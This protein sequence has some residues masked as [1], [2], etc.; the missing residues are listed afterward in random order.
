M[1]RMTAAVTMLLVGCGIL[2]GKG[3]AQER[4]LE[5]Q[6]TPED[7]LVEIVLTDGS[8]LVGR[9]VEAGDPFRFTLVSGVEMNIPV[10]NVRSIARAEGMVE[11]GEYYRTDPNRTRLFFGPTAR[12]LPSGQGYLAVYEIFM[13]FVGVAITDRFIM[14]AGTP[15]IFDDDWDRPFWVAPKLKVFDSGK[16]QG[17][18]GVLAVGVEEDTFGLLYGV[19]T[20][21][22]EKGS[23][24]LGMGYGF[25]NS[26]LSDKP[27]LMIGGEA[28]GSQRVKFVTE[29]YIIPGEGGLLS[30]GPRFF[31]EKL[32][33]DL[34]L[35]L[36]IGADD[37]V[38][39]PLVNFVYNF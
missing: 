22:D 38:V 20:R 18:V 37:F 21:G 12:T 36:P 1:G 17:A 23:F 28:R 39:F 5:I 8:T 24:T 14:A 10:A 3:A 27:F 9:V 13:P 33:A 2:V 25:E 6:V 16:T 31:G 30:A 19:L 32:S 35:V 34:G 7:Q 15:L 11:E 29:N 26:D 4:P